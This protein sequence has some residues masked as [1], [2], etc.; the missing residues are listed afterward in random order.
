MEI[1]ILLEGQKNLHIKKVLDNIILGLRKIGFKNL[2]FYENSEDVLLTANKKI[3]IVWS[4]RKAEYLKS[5]G[6]DVLVC[7][8]SYLAHRYNYVSLAWNGLNN[9]GKFFDYPPDKGARFFKMGLSLKDWKLNKDSYVLILGQVP[10]D[11]SLKNE[12]IQKLYLDWIQILEEKNEKIIFRHHPESLK[13]KK[14]WNIPEKYI[15]PNTLIDDISNAKYSLCFNSNSAVD[16]IINGIPCVAMDSGTMVYDICGKNIG[17]I[18]TPDREETFYRLAWKQF[19]V[20]EIAEGWPL[21]N[22][23]EILD[24]DRNK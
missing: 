18:I 23:L 8:M 4:Y 2:I 11:M 19:T 6:Y 7:E 5:K 16:S 1:S 21:K 22:L 9:Y 12:N 15:V 13:F 17:D 3:I 24:R 14:K 10:G 20:Q